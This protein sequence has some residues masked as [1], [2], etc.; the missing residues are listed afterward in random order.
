MNGGLLSKDSR[1]QSSDI[2]KPISSY[3][4]PE[5]PDEIEYQFNTGTL[6]STKMGV[7]QKEKEGSDL[8]YL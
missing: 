3:T 5:L 7:K 8:A 4:T 1:G 2:K 6:N